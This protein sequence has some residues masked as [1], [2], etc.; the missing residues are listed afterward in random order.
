MK[1]IFSEVGIARF[2]YEA[3]WDVR[4]VAIRKRLRDRERIFF[5][6]IEPRSRV[7]DVAAGNSLLPRLLKEKKQCAVAIY[8]I[9]EKIITEQAAY[10][11]DARKINLS[12]DSFRL[13]QDY[14]Y[15]I[16]SE[17]LEHLPLPE[18]VLKKVAPHARFLIISVPNSAFYR[19]RLQLLGGRF[20][21]QWVAH[22]SEHLRFWSHNDFLEWLDALGL[23]V[24]DT[25]A[26]NGLDIGPLKFYRW[27]PNL[28]G[29]QMVYLCRI[30]NPVE[31][32][33]QG[34]TLKI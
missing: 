10:G 14:D 22:P 24:L 16:L 12:D 8:D 5:N 20:F 7:L 17:V 4:D 29:H 11:L 34:L 13:E 9:S 26:S 18:V 27:L 1:N 21:K 31:N 33:A 15:V 19:F 6:W 32:S 23:V 30:K 2:D 25:Q 28:F 3:Y